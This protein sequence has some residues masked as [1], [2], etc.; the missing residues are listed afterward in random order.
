MKKKIIVAII[1]IG[2]LMVTVVVAAINLPD[3][4]Q[5]LG[6]ETALHTKVFTEPNILG[7]VN[8]HHKLTIP[9]FSSAP[10][11]ADSYKIISNDYNLEVRDLA[12]NNVPDSHN[13]GPNCYQ[14][15]DMT[16]TIDPRAFENRLQQRLGGIGRI[17]VTV[18]VFTD[19]STQS[20]PQDRARLSWRS[21]AYAISQPRLYNGYGEGE[22]VPVDNDDYT[23]PGPVSGLNAAGV[24]NVIEAF[25]FEC[26]PVTVSQHFETPIIIMPD[27]FHNVKGVYFRVTFYQYENQHAPNQVL[28]KWIV[29]T[30]PDFPNYITV[31][32]SGRYR[33]TR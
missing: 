24:V 21:E 7:E 18:D 6:T 5:T 14:L 23:V 9:D 17:G 8:C 33:S 25:E 12:F 11:N 3:T 4:G 31:T 1:C 10:I 19:N 22:P 2:M 27:P 20:N 30:D 15:T 13:L 26:D 28:S 16:L 32:F 29:G